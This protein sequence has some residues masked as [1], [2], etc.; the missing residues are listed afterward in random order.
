MKFTVAI[1]GPAASGK[2]T[3]SRRISEYFGFSYLDTGLI[4]RFIGLKVLS[5]FDPLEAIAQLNYDEIEVEG[6]RT[7]AVSKMASQ[8]A[9]DIKVRNALVEYQREFS[10]RCGGAVLDGRDIGTVICPNAEIKLYITASEEIRA[11]RRFQELAEKDKGLTIEA[12]IVELRARDLADKERKVSPLLKAEDAV[13][14]DTTELSI[15][16]SVA[17]AVNAISKVIRLST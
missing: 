16:A 12:L 11:N 6:L 1:D 4:Y 9:S 15:D 7:E 10:R 8:I 2:G 5:G 14:L 13:L 17:L 3:I